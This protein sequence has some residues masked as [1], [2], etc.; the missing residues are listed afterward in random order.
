MARITYK[1]YNQGQGVLFPVSYDSKIPED[2]PVRLISQI[3][4]EL[5]LTGINFGYK[6]GA[7]SSYHPRILLKVLFYA[8]LKNIYSCRKIEAELEQNIHY[9]WLSGDQHPN[10]RTINNSRSLRLKKSIH[11]LFVQVVYML[12]DIGLYY[13]ERD[14]H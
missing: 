8:Y 2:H 12:V 6:G 9:I 4:D 10:F 3:V 7:N 14:L 11:K 13:V 1:P 5:D